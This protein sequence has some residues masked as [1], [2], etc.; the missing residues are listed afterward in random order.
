MPKDWSRPVV[1]WEMEAKDPEKQAAF[2]RELFNWEIGDGPIRQIGPGLG[3]PETITGHI[4]PGE[5][6]AVVL[7]IQV[8][9]L[10]DTLDRV[11][12]LGGAVLRE[13]FDPP[14]GGPTLA[15]ITDPEGTRVMLV[16]Q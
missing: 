15:S 8:L 5:R 16:Q 9:S 2:Y 4:R 10:R 1:H 14:G 13:P 3:A 12:G 7:F 11:P 6:S